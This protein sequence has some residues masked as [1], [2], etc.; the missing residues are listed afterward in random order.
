MYLEINDDFSPLSVLFSYLSHNWDYPNS[1]ILAFF[2]EKETSWTAHISPE[3][4]AGCANF[5][6]RKNCPVFLLFSAEVEVV[7]LGIF[8]YCM[9]SAFPFPNPYPCP[10]DLHCLCLRNFTKCAHKK[11]RGREGKGERLV[12]L[13]K[14]ESALCAYFHDCLYRQ[15]QQRTY[16]FASSMREP[17]KVFIFDLFK[18]LASCS[19]EGERERM[20]GEGGK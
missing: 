16:V 12:G 6:P 1:L 18:K 15:Q 17:I 3:L 14:S 11:G 10:I 5:G 8:P 7:A 2:V 4:S 20:L 13:A 19:A 9:P